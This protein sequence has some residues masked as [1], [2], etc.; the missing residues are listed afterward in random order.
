MQLQSV[1]PDAAAKPV[2]LAGCHGSV[3]AGVLKSAMKL[4]LA[5][6]TAQG[7]RFVPNMEAPRKKC[8]GL[9]SDVGLRS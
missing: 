3:G 6:A 5:R 1:C 9:A 7:K 8:R 4:H 2:Y